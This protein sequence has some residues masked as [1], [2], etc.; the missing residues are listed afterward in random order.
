M[1]CYRVKICLSSWR[2]FEC[3]M[4][5]SVCF[6]A[7]YWVINVRN[8]CSSGTFVPQFLQSALSS[9][10]KNFRNFITYHVQDRPQQKLLSRCTEDSKVKDVFFFYTKVSKLTILLPVQI[11][12]AFLACST[13]QRIRVDCST[14]PRS[15]SPSAVLSVVW[16][17]IGLLRHMWLPL[18]LFCW[19]IAQGIRPTS[20]LLP[21]SS[22]YVL[23]SFQLS[24]FFIFSSIFFSNCPPQNLE[25]TWGCNQFQRNIIQSKNSPHSMEP[26]VSQPRL[27]QSAW[28]P[29][30]CHMNTLKVLSYS[31]NL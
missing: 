24:P 20:A 15:S 31:F 14:S 9:E 27:Q 3:K 5:S 7:N 4:K 18:A 1:F 8:I 26:A 19:L 25:R 16:N 6:V 30:L 23:P 11:R 28:C 10:D 2:A 21:R 17:A 22:F 29:Y 12:N 13:H